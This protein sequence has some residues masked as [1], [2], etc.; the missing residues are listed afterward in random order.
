MASDLFGLFVWVCRQVKIRRRMAGCGG[1][2]S[3]VYRGNH[4]NQPHGSLETLPIDVIVARAKS[5][6]MRDFM[7][8]EPQVPSTFQA[9]EK[10]ELITIE[11]P[12]SERH[13][14]NAG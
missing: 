4:G 10:D 9:L 7:L 6:Q 12:G 13:G 1:P 11:T 2:Q 8:V 5:N 3:W 14:N